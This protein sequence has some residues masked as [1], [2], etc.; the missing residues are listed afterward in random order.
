MSKY[1]LRIPEATDEFTISA[2]YKYDYNF[3]CGL[4][5]DTEELGSNL[6]QEDI[7]NVLTALLA[8]N[9]K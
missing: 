1:K 8:R 6:T 7:Q 2:G 3:L 5:E 9:N 4:V